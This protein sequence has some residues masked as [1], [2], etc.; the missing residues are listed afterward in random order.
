MKTPHTFL[1]GLL[2]G[3]ALLATV[4]FVHQHLNTPVQHSGTYLELSTNYIQNA[5]EYRALCYQAYNTAGQRLENMLATM[6]RAPGAKPLAVV[7]DID[8]TVLD[9]SP[10]QA[11]QALQGGQFPEGWTEWCNLAQ[12]KA[13]P[14]AL[15]F[16]KLVESKG[17][18]VYYITNRRTAEREGT[19]NNLRALGFPNVQDDHFYFRTD[20][21]DKTKRR[22]K[23][24][25]THDIIMFCG[26]NLGDFSGVFDKQPKALRQ[27]ATD[28]LM[29]HFG[30]HWIVLPN[31]MYGDWYGAMIN[32]NYA[33]PWQVQDSLRRLNLRGY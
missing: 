22:E 7:V 8:E 29:R 25:L 13:V 33:Q 9:N 31:P 23:V 1:L 12:A 14:G 6:R 30:E 11:R 24:S 32:Y 3:A 16:L 27:T 21:S 20:E 4:G 26:D 2:T 17:I 28:S 19:L 10:Y 15:E 5:A 18:A